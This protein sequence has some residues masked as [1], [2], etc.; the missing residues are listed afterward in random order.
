MLRLV[1]VVLA[2]LVALPPLLP[3][4][5]VVERP[6]WRAAFDS[7]GVTGTVA[8][9]RLGSDTTEVHDLARAR[10]G[11]IPASTF[12]IPNSLIALELGVVRDERDPFPK[13]WPDQEIAPW[14]RDHTFRTAFK[15]SVV[16]AYQQI[17]REVGEARYR[18]WL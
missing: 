2:L 8:I 7:A 18:D 17:A 13:T 12:K 14:N 9:R 16:P 3:A 15:Y 5:V 4:Q 6:A 10:R 11:F 1:L